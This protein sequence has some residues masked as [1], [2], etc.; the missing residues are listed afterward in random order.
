MNPVAAA[1]SVTMVVR[2]LRLLGLLANL[3]HDFQV[4]VEDCSD[5]RQNIRLNDP[6]PD[7]LCAPN[8]DIDHTLKGQVPF[9]HIHHI[10]IPALLEN[11]DQPLDPAI[12][13]QNVA[14]PTRRSGEIGEMVKRIDEREG[15]SAVEGAA[16]IQGRG[17]AHACLIGTGYAEVGFPHD[18]PVL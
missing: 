15:R 16:V 5:D 10:L 2:L 4:I 11:A 6:G 13:S 8:P 17:D 14:D 18:D 7:G 9:P 12:D 3:L 1:M